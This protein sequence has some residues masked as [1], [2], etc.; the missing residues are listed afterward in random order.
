MG[1]QPK[2]KPASSA[3]GPKVRRLPAGGEWIRTISTAE[4]SSTSMQSAL[5]RAV[6]ALAD[7]KRGHM[8]SCQSLR[9]SP[10]TDGS[11]PVPSS[12]ESANFRS[13]RGGR[14]RIGR[15]QRIEFAEAASE[16]TWLAIALF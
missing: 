2:L 8:T 13:L 10:G 11:N 14:R 4:D 15:H 9:A 12:G 7:T 1:L 3:G 16:T 5:V 6:F